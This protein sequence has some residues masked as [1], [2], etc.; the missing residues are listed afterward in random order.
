MLQNA[1]ISL[2]TALLT[3]VGS[4]L[5]MRHRLQREFKLQYR[6]ETVARKLL[7]HPTWRWRTFKIIKHHLGGFEDE[8]LRKILVQAGAVKFETKVG[9]EIWGLY[10]RVGSILEGN[11]YPVIDR[12]FSVDNEVKIRKNIPK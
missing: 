11:R 6:A 5:V 9:D 2:I 12:P 1:A 4:Y 10:D 7:N 8:E 3:S